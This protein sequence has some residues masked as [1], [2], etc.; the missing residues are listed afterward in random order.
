MILACSETRIEL[1]GQARFRRE[2]TTASH[3]FALRDIN[4]TGVRPNLDHEDIP[5]MP[6]L[7]R[8]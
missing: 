8:Q 5:R 3:V 1:P 4:H 6:L 2:L 7:P